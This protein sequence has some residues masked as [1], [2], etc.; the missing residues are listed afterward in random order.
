MP[1]SLFALALVVAVAT[2]VPA[3]AREK[4]REAR[5][6]A[7]IREVLEKYLDARFRGAEWKEFRDLV[8]W[9]DEQQQQEEQEPDG[10]ACTAI[11]RSYN[12]QDIRLR[13][14]SNDDKRTALATVV[15]YQ[16]GT[17]CAAEHAFQ[18]APHLES[19]IFQLRKR[20]IVWAVEKTNRPG[21]Q[22]DWTVVRDRLQQ[23]LG[24]PARTAGLSPEARARAAASLSALTRTA[25]AIGRTGAE[26][27][28][29]PESSPTP[30]PK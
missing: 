19:A 3:V 25:N 11:V 12:I 18:P 6:R 26:I 1:R 21:G 9:T 14:S 2:V 20:S 8:T 30:A 27:R 7:E 17:Y 16:L 23:Q 5:A 28:G 22:V 24:D 13:G 10:A 4:D 29:A 15:F